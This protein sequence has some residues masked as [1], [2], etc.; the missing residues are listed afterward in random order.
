MN[1]SA[2][3]TA[4]QPALK[5]VTFVEEVGALAAIRNAGCAAVIWN[6]APLSQMRAWLDTLEPSQ[7]PQTRQILQPDRVADVVTQVCDSCGT[8]VGIER[9]AL[10]RDVASLAQNFATLMGVSSLRL[11]LDVVTTNACRKF[12]IDAVTARLVC[13]YRGQSTQFGEADR[14][15]DSDEI[16]STPPTCPLVLRGTKWPSDIPTRLR[17]RSPPI[18][19]TGETRLVLVLDPIYDLAEEI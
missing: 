18:E 3:I 8:P 15:H 12:H 10:I 14:G 7:L 4:A 13:T 19:G 17:H 2:Q 6:R 9:Q 11:R 16:L 5:S 1:I